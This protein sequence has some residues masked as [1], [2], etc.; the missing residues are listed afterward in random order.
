MITK[1]VEPDEVGKLLSIVGAV[2]SFIPIISSPLFGLLYRNTVSV[3]PSTFLYVLAG[4]Q[5]QCY[6]NYQT[7]F[8]SVLC[9]LVDIGLH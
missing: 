9:G 2:Q 6:E 3:Y 8:R 5:K 4:G 1:H 7:T